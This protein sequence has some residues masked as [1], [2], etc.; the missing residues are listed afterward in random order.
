MSAF[1]LPKLT[2]FDEDQRERNDAAKRRLVLG[3]KDERVQEKRQKLMAQNREYSQAYYLRRKLHLESPEFTE[4][5]A[6]TQYLHSILLR[7]R[8]T[9]SSL[10]KLD[11]LFE[12]TLQNSY[13]TPLRR[14]I[15]SLRGFAQ[16]MW[17]SHHLRVRSPI[18]LFKQR[19]LFTF[20]V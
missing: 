16:E 17:Q 20:R 6:Q 11:E 10:D 4:E 2:E 18:N 19:S 12:Q 15:P 8:L 14:L 3:F 5:M 13:V 9:L 7:T 1:I